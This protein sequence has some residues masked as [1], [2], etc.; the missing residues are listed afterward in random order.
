MNLDTYKILPP[1]AFH[2]VRP[3]ED[4]ISR[5]IFLDILLVKPTVERKTQVF[6]KFCQRNFQPTV[7]KA[8]EWEISIIIMVNHPPSSIKKKQLKILT[9]FLSKLTLDC[10]TS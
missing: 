2:K 3:K 4:Q 5:S 8:Q 9:R 7:W 6:L 1:K 10:I